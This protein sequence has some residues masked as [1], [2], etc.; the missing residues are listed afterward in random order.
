MFAKFQSQQNCP[1]R[2]G[3]HREN[4]PVAG[5]LWAAL[6]LEQTPRSHRLLF[7]HLS[8][9]LHGTTQWRA[10]Q[11]IPA[12]SHCNSQGLTSALFLSSGRTSLPSTVTPDSFFFPTS[13]DHRD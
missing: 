12:T 6:E 8:W 5:I 13:L 10:K 11:A 4:W 1:S 9:A 2:Q 3:S 7:P